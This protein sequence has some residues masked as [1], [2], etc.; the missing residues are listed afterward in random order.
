M[1]PSTGVEDVA[2]AQLR[3]V[4]GFDLVNARGVRRT[5]TPEEQTVF[6]S[7]VARRLR[8]LR[9]KASEA[10]GLSPRRRQQA[11]REAAILATWLRFLGVK[12][13]DPLLAESALGGA[14][15]WE[16]E[17]ARRLEKRPR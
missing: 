2:R 6:L 12:T 4:G 17:T 8:S 13:T 15:P 14:D 16:A 10:T 7:N 3:E 11:D 1:I 5:M 9:A